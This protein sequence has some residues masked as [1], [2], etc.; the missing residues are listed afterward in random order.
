MNILTPKQ[1]GKKIFD[2]LSKLDDVTV[3]IGDRN[4]NED[5]PNERTHTIVNTSKKNT[6]WNLIVFEQ[7]GNIK[8]L[9]KNNTTSKFDKCCIFL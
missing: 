8:V 3:R 1:Q 7:K 2:E 9:K 5:G 6:T 4:K